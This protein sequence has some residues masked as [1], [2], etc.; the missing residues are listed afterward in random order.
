MIF[1]FYK[2]SYR[3]QVQSVNLISTSQCLTF[4]NHSVIK[5]H[6]NLAQQPLPFRSWSPLIRL[7]LCFSVPKYFLE[8]NGNLGKD[9]IMP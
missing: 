3:K 2:Q 5:F 7:L 4:L 1:H 8:V 6:K 9:N